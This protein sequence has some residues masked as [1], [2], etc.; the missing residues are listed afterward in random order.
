[1]T[2]TLF[3]HSTRDSPFPIAVVGSVSVWRPV[4]SCASPA[5]RGEN[6]ASHRDPSKVKP[7]PRSARERR[8]EGKYREYL[9]HRGQRPAPPKPGC[10]GGRVQRDFQHGLLVSCNSDSQHIFRAG[11]PG[12]SCAGRRP[13]WVTNSRF[14]PSS[15]LASRAPH[16]GIYAAN[17]C[18]RT[19]G[20]RPSIRVGR[21]ASAVGPAARR[22]DEAMPQRIVEEAQRGRWPHAAATRRARGGCGRRPRRTSSP[23]RT[24]IDSPRFLSAARKTHARGP[25]EYSDGLLG[26]SAA[27]RS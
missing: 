25:R 13:R 14:A 2:A 20:A 1:M 9:T 24:G 27:C 22:A 21:V 6:P 26:G 23:M 8:Q 12:C 16:C 4:S 7:K 5:A 3:P 19:L 17:H 10:I 11:P 18:Y 15:R